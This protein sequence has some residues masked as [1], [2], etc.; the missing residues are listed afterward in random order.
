MIRPPRI[1]E[2]II[3]SPESEKYGPYRSI[4]DT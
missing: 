2:I 4:P 3:G 1:E